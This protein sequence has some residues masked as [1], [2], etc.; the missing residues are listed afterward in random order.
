MS[1]IEEEKGLEVVVAGGYDIKVETSQIITDYD[2]LHV[3]PASSLSNIDLKSVPL[4][5][6]QAID[7]AKLDI[8]TK[9][10][11]D[12]IITSLREDINSLDEGVYKRTFIDTKISYLENLITQ[13]VGKDAVASIA[14]S[15]VA[16]ATVDIARTSDI[17]TLNTRVENSET[18]ITKVKETINTNDTARAKQINEAIAS[19][20]R[21]LAQ[22]SEVIDLEIDSEGNIKA[23]KIEELSLKL[24]TN[25]N[26]ISDLNNQIQTT[27]TNISAVTKDI[28]TLESTVTENK[29]QVNSA[30]AHT[31][32]LKFDGDKDYITGFEVVSSIN[33]DGSHNITK[34]SSFKVRSDTFEIIDPISGNRVVMD[35][36]GLVFRKNDNTEYKYLQTVLALNNKA[37]NVPIV[38]NNLK[39][40]PNVLIAPGNM[41]VYKQAYKEQDQNFVFDKVDVIDTVSQ[42]GTFTFTPRAQLQLAQNTFTKS[43]QGEFIDSSSNTKYSNSYKVE[44]TLGSVTLSYSLKS[45]QGTGTANTYNRRKCKVILQISDNNSSFSDTSSQ[46][47]MDFGTSLNYK[48]G[49][50]THNKTINQGKYLRLKFVYSNKGGTFT[51]GSTGY[52]DYNTSSTTFESVYTANKAWQGWKNG[53]SYDPQRLVKRGYTLQNLSSNIISTD[54]C[55]AVRQHMLHESPS[56]VYVSFYDPNLWPYC[57]TCKAVINIK[58]VSKKWIT[59]SGSSQIYNSADNL[60]L[61]AFAKS[62]SVLA[63]GTLNIIVVE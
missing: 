54:Y 6:Q 43:L 28:N 22:Y 55:N 63:E 13:K 9:T 10:L 51:T 35:E 16:L 45:V 40:T 27:N 58:V 29:T 52:W 34:E 53:S 36:D 21:N 23:Q 24:K 42:N 60:S 19:I 25:K 47:E 56:G 33:E 15:R 18:E 48:N 3:I 46:N 5:I 7:D 20:N 57:A 61:S 50:I 30:F 31:S 41:P 8:K 37:N 4:I 39:R 12:G 59:K 38:I 44:T 11:A 2:G 1:A 17:T 62:A 32:N 14:D 49:S 26:Q